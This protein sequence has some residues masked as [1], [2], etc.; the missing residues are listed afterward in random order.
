[1][2]TESDEDAVR[3]ERADGGERK[4]ET[5]AEADAHSDGSQDDTEEG[6]TPDQQ[7]E[8]LTTQTG[9]VWEWLPSLVVGLFLFTFLVLVV[10][11]ATPLPVDVRSV[12]P[13]WFGVYVII[14]GASALT[15]IGAKAFRDWQEITGN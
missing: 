10:A 13:E 12:P 15:T 2:T 5:P 1:M 9:L 11:S 7:D 3:T 8:G 6:A 14:V 4:G